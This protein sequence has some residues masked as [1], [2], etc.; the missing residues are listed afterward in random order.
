MSR[1]IPESTVRRLA[2]YLRVLESF[3]REGTQTASSGEHARRGN[4]TAAQVRKDL[5]LFGSFGTRGLGYGVPELAGE[6]REILGLDR[7]WRVALA[8]AGRLGSALFDYEAFRHRGFQIVLVVDSD[9]AKVGQHWDGLTIRPVE[10]F[11][12]GIRESEVEIL[13]TAVPANA[14]QEIVDRAVQ[15]GV[16]AILNFAPLQLHVPEGVEVT[17]VD[18]GVE[19]GTLSFALGTSAKRSG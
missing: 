6:L 4:T 18:M 9:S 17:D 8:G 7:T 1:G 5:S 16:R 14:V 3:E 15:A 19:L 11:E 10:E 2:I 13:I 12:A